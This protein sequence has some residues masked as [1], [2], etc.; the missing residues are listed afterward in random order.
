[1][2]VFVYEFATGGGLL[3]SPDAAPPSGS[4]LREG[5]AMVLAIAEDFAALADCDVVLLRDHRLDVGVPPLGGLGAEDS[6]LKPGLQHWQ[7]VEVDN[8]DDEREAF[9][10]QAAAADWTVVIAPEFG[11]H[12]LNRVRLV[13]AVNGRLLGP[14][15]EV[16][17]LGADKQAT[18]DHF[19][20]HGLPIAQGERLT[21]DSQLSHLRFPV[22]LKPVDGAGSMGVR[23]VS[24]REQLTFGADDDHRIEEYQA[25]TPASVAVLRGT[26]TT[27]VLPACEQRLAG[28]GSFEYL[29]GRLPLDEPLRSRAESL[30]RR[31]AETLTPGVGYV[32]FDMVLGD[33]EHDDVLIELNPRLT[34]SYVGLRHLCQQNLAAA[35]IELAEGGE[36]ELCFNDGPIEFSA[37]GTILAQSRQM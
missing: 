35:M 33:D 18:A 26:T 27:L 7:I 14:T 29:G 17:A 9:R 24:C 11:G 15:P 31:A 5:M 25:G 1:M 6:R 12:L 2:R 28:G 21:V 10:S 13:E 36:P 16:V 37:D 19:A 32:G 22:V 8:S 34:T 3:S 30:A 4:L 20:R 23:L